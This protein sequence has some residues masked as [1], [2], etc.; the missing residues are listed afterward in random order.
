MGDAIRAVAEHPLAA[1][2]V[3]A[4][5]YG[6][7]ALLLAG[8][9]EIVEKAITSVFYARS[10]ATVAERQYERNAAMESK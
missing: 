8:V 2:G 3:M 5:G 9:K 1:L 4:Y 10:A 7:V 6:C